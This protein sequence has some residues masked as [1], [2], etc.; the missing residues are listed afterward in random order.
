MK[1]GLGLALNRHKYQSSG[2]YN[3]SY[4]NNSVNYWNSKGHS[5]P[6]SN[7]LSALDI[8]MQSLIDAGIDTKLD[9]LWILATD[10]DENVAKTN[11]INPG[12]YDLATVGTVTFTENQGF[13]GDGASGYLRTNFVP[14][15]HGVNWDGQGLD[16]SF[17][18]Y[19]RI[20][21]TTGHPMGSGFADN[22][23]RRG[24][25]GNINSNS[26]SAS[27]AAPN[28]YHLDLNSL[29]KLV[30][31]SGSEVY[32]STS[33]SNPDSSNEF[34]IL[35]EAVGSALCNCQ[36]SMAFIGASLASKASSLDS[37][38]NTY[39]SSL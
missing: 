39:I 24:L 30:F 32:S 29:E 5:L 33:T 31:E 3:T 10:G 8:F 1:L 6:S 36:I 23:K 16:A 12:T 20:A 7:T 34:T 9:C 2:A 21:G 25:A 19:Y 22:S 38:L 11:I 13:A 14:A 28:L 37:A 35:A 4:V 26:V 27:I 18:F 15:T 17:G